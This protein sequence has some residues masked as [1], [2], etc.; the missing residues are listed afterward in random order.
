MKPGPFLLAWL[1][2]SVILFALNGIFHGV[3]AAIFF[4]THL[5]VLGDAAVKMKDFKPVP[6]II[7][8]LLLDFCLVI[9]ITR[10]K[11]E[12]VVM[13]EAVLI[14]GLFYLSTAATWSLA[15]TA[16]L[17]SWPGHRYHG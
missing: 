13:K 12:K 11:N 2:T 15:N 14:G 9:I 3:V 1:V 10:V 5:S 16:T 6:I 4:D 7:L 8:E 17:M